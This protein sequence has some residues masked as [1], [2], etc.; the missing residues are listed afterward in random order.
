MASPERTIFEAEE[1][2]DQAIWRGARD[3]DYKSELTLC[4]EAK[5]ILDGLTGLDS[6]SEK[7]RRRALSQC[8][9]RIDHAYVGL[10]DH[11]WS[12]ERTSEALNLAETSGSAVQIARALYS[13]GSAYLYARDIP[14]AERQ[15]V[16]LLLLAEEYPD[17]KEMQNVVGLTLITRGHVLIGKSLYQQAARVLEDA[18]STLAT[19]GDYFGCA[20]ACD[21]LADLYIKLDAPEK[22]HTYKAKSEEYKER[23]SKQPNPYDP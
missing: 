6:I 23:I 10:G 7:H 3:H 5:I 18:Y 19:V 1:L 2:I 11:E 4:S 12:I 8:L 17:D 21:L 13:L 9:L 16:R 15:W 22:S 20:S 14:S